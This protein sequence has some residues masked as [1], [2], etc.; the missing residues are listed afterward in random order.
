[1]EVSIRASIHAVQQLQVQITDLQQQLQLETK[2]MVQTALQLVPES[3]SREVK[4]VPDIPIKDVESGHAVTAAPSPRT[5]PTVW[6]QPD[7]ASVQPAPTCLERAM[8]PCD[9]QPSL[10]AATDAVVNCAG[11]VA[12]LTSPHSGTPQ[13]VDPSMK[14]LHAVQPVH[15]SGCFASS[16]QFASTQCC[17]T[18]E[19]EIVDQRPWQRGLPALVKQPDIDSDLKEIPQERPMSRTAL[20]P[21]VKERAEFEQM[22]NDI[23]V[24]KKQ[25]KAEGKNGR[26]QKKDKKRRTR[27][28]SGSNSCLQ[29]QAQATAV[30]SIRLQERAQLEAPPAK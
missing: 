26:Q 28:S 9:P 3:K 25:W 12:Q 30:H 6:L 19:K 15:P 27:R 4:Q 2:G 18:V 1:L 21:F 5:L 29:Q 23:L 22:L 8:S 10:T 11:K 20:K 7:T 17:A 14:L 24:C 13:R 16:S